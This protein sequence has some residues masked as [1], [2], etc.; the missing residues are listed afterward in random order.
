MLMGDAVDREEVYPDPRHCEA[1]RREGCQEFG[2]LE[3]HILP[4]VQNLREDFY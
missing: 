3:N 2:Y 4:Q 1:S